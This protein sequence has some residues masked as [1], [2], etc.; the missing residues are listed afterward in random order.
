MAGAFFSSHSAQQQFEGGIVI[1]PIFH[2][3]KLSSKRW[4][5]KPRV[6]LWPALKWYLFEWTFFKNKS[7]QDIRG[8][9]DGFSPSEHTQFKKQNTVCTHSPPSLSSQFT[10]SP[11]LQGHARAWLPSTQVPLACSRTSWS[12]N[13]TWCH[14]V[15]LLLLYLV[16]EI[17]H[18]LVCSRLWGSILVDVCCSTMTGPVY[19]S[20]LLLMSVWLVSSWGLLNSAVMNN[21]C[22]SLSVDIHACSWWFELGVEVLGQRCVYFLFSTFSRFYNLG[23]WGK[24]WTCSR[25]WLG[26]K[27]CTQ[28]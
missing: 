18:V 2:V 19:L 28:I 15:E 7:A 4:N 12:L 21:S 6:Y 8:Q 24:R 14:N 27:T 25:Y 22:A 3:K 1:V 17:V 9:P 23:N 11:P 5:E 16:C 13:H 20:I 26:I 10:A